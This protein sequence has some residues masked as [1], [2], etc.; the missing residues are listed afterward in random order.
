MS[1]DLTGDKVRVDRWLW[2]AR[3]FKTRSLA[4]EAVDGGKVQVNGTRVKRSKLVEVG[5]VL[6]IRKP[7]YEYTID[8]RGLSEHRGPAKTAQTLYEERPASIHARGLLRE[9]LRYQPTTTYE[10]KGRPT[11]KQRREIRRLKRRS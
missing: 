10:G 1:K 3:F 9:R 4:A 8:V 5:D 7:P 6:R 11:K 2:A